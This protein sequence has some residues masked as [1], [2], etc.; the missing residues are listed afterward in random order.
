MRADAIKGL[1]VMRRER[2]RSKPGFFFVRL[3]RRKCRIASHC[4]RSRTIHGV[5]RV[6]VTWNHVTGKE[7]LKFKQLAHVLI[8]KADR[9]FRG[10]L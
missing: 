2:D 7:A 9:L 5:E 8:E 6:S 10:M 3:P 1:K 4:W